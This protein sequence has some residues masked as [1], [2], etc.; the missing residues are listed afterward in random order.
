M[1]HPELMR[2]LGLALVFA[3]AL[4]PLWI[5][6]RMTGAKRADFALCLVALIV[7]AFF[8]LLLTTYVRHGLLVSV[9]T[10]ALAYTVVLEL[11]YLK[12]LAIA[13]IQLVLTWLF[14]V[15]FAAALVGPR[16]MRVFHA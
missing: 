6:A 7:A 11:E 9:L 15:V 14:V 13:A 5:G 2:L 10:S 8:V 12:A 1:H 4:A 3:V 16:L